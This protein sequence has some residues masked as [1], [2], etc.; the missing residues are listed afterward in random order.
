MPIVRN[1]KRIE[2]VVTT[3]NKFRAKVQ[4]SNLD[5]PKYE[6][7]VG[8][9]SWN[10]GKGQEFRDTIL[11]KCHRIMMALQKEIDSITHA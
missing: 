4:P 5:H 9:E 10:N 7:T 6:V 3:T 8:S 2:V 11:I 1:Y